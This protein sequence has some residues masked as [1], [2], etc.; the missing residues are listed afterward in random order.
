[1]Q[2]SNPT[3]NN[4]SLK[5]A[6]R[7]TTSDL[8][9]YAENEHVSIVPRFAAPALNLICGDYGPFTPQRE[10]EVPLWLAIALKQQMKCFIRCPEWMTVESLKDIKE[11]EKSSE[12]GSLADLPFHYMEISSMILQVAADDIAD[13]D[14]VRSLLEDIENLRAHKIRFGLVRMGERQMDGQAVNYI[15]L[16]KVSAM[17]LHSIRGLLFTTLK[18]FYKMYKG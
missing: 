4:N 10:I 8:E 15:R 13:V 1:M 16:N 2:P 12:I 14:R 17:E 7:F 9:F 11:Q 18:E 5:N 3:D 6:N